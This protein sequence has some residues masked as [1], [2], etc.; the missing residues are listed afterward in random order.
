ME[1]EQIIKQVELVRS[2]TLHTVDQI[3]DEIANII[4]AGFNNNIR[5]NLGHI[6]IVQD[7]LASQFAGIPQQLAPEYLQLF[8][9]HTSPKDWKTPVPRLKDI[10]E[11]LTRQTEF[12][13]THLENRL[14]EKAVKPFKRM[15]YEMTTI[16]EILSFS[17][18]HE[19]M[20]VGVIGVQRRQI[21]GR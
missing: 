3:T 16:G 21:E 12:I 4:P 20:H 17:L 10:T 11:Q 18:H 9:N 2:I 8:A 19:G 13:K 1:N 15:G 6:L 14:Q 7:Q 5:W